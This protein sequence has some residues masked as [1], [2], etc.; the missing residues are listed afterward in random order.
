MLYLKIFLV[1]VSKNMGDITCV[2]MESGKSELK[3]YIISMYREKTRRKTLR[4]YN[5]EPWKMGVINYS[6]Y[7]LL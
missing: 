5:N 4:C 2:L 6:V 3:L 1:A 7:M